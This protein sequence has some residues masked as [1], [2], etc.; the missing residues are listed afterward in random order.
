MM[1]YFHYDMMNHSQL[2]EDMDFFSNLKESVEREKI[3][4]WNVKNWNR[5]LNENI[6]KTYMD[7]KTACLISSCNSSNPF[8]YPL[9]S[10]PLLH[11]L[12]GKTNGIADQVMNDLGNSIRE[13]KE[14]LSMN[15][16][17]EENTFRK[18]RIFLSLSQQIDRLDLLIG[19][20]ASK[21]FDLNVEQKILQEPNIEFL[22]EANKLRKF[23]S[24]STSIE[25]DSQDGPPGK[26]ITKEAL[27]KDSLNEKEKSIES[28]FLENPPPIEEGISS[29]LEQKPTLLEEIQATESFSQGSSPSKSPR[30]LEESL[31]EE[32]IRPSQMG[33]FISENYFSFDRLEL[34]NPSHRKEAP[35]IDEPGEHE[36]DFG[37]VMIEMPSPKMKQT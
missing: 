26:A 13:C 37:F 28:S 8:K 16:I 36:D 10:T 18:C 23:S 30:D 33:S 35:I 32:Q 22:E 11:M 2:R 24:A 34:P 12:G 17:E 14:S 20:I 6:S 3:Q 9:F 5:L 19:I 7:V 25:E 27:R 31:V 15:N 21:V 1:T 4:S 29:K